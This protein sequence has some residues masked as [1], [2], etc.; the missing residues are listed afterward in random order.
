MRLLY[1]DKNISTAIIIFCLGISLKW[2]KMSEEIAHL[3]KK[4]I[5]ENV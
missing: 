4:G 5:K 2:R 1:L 3:I